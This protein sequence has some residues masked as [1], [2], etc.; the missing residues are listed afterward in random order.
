MGLDQYRSRGRPAGGC[1]ARHSGPNQY[2]PCRCRASLRVDIRGRVQQPVE[3]TLIPEPAGLS[4]QRLGVGDDQHGFSR[5]RAGAGVDGVFVPGMPGEESITN[6]VRSRCAGQS[7]VLVLSPNG[8]GP[9]RL[10]ELGDVPG[11][12]RLAVVAHRARRGTVRAI[13]DGPAWSRECRALITG[14]PRRDR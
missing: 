11:E 3:V 13:A 7:P 9:R 4:V 1:L 10:G 8:P 12:L 5:A 2:L 6:R 14:P